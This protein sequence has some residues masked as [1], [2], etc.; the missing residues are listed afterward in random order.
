M[1]VN[2]G[3]KIYSAKFLGVPALLCRIDSPLP[4]LLENQFK[5]VMWLS[6]TAAN[7]QA[8]K[9]PVLMALR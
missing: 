6:E 8:G 3:R 7:W 2:L 9:Q 4:S 1:S 5:K